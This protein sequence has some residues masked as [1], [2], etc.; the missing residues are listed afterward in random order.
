M[1]ETPRL[2]AAERRFAGARKA[3]PI[4][5]V[6]C[7]TLDLYCDREKCPN[8]FN[9]GPAEYTEG[10]GRKCRRGARKDGWVF[11]RDGTTTCPA[12]AALIAA[13]PKRPKP[14][15]QDVSAGKRLRP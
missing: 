1:G 2:T 15:E 9:Q 10:T 6:G 12:C 5:W 13:K 4:P 7:Y 8:R 14:E 3:D 11:H